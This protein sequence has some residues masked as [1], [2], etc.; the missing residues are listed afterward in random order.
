M[1]APA[2]DILTE[3]PSAELSRFFLTHRDQVKRCTLFGNHRGRWHEKNRFASV[4]LVWLILQL[5]SSVYS[6][7]SLT[8]QLPRTSQRPEVLK[9]DDLF[10]EREAALCFRSIAGSKFRCLSLK[11]GCC[12]IKRWDIWCLSSIN[13]VAKRLLKLTDSFVYVW[14]ILG[15]SGRMAMQYRCLQALEYFATKSACR[16]V[17]TRPGHM[18]QET[19]DK[20]AEVLGLNGWMHC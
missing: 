15:W 19:W 7:R 14:V 8:S 18:A 9:I 5:N 10:G 12:W 17:Q 13:V 2:V 6:G 1:S 16:S 4:P 11:H 20:Y 3:W